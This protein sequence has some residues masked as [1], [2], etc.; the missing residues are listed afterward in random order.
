MAG[1]AAAGACLGV[2]LAAAASAVV[3]EEGSWVWAAHY[4]PQVSHKEAVFLCLLLLLLLLLVVVV[5]L[6]LVRVSRLL[7]LLLA[8]VLVWVLQLLRFGRCSISCPCCPAAAHM[9]Q[10]LAGLQGKHQSRANM[11]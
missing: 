4:V 3:V 2:D 5:L 6:L 10:V 8:W 1:P 9:V 11:G 7:L